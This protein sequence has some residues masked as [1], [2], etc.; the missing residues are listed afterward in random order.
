[1]FT[2]TTLKIQGETLIICAL[3]SLLGTQLFGRRAAQNKDYFLVLTDKQ[4][5][6]SDTLITALPSAPMPVLP[7]T[8]AEGVDSWETRF[9]R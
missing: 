5:G 6:A 9:V 4:G 1:M 7:R 3:V 8:N 2:P